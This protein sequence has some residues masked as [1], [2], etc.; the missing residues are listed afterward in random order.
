MDD[1]SRAATAETWDQKKE[2]VGQAWAKTQE[3]YG[4]VKASTTL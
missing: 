1:E 2:K 3:A 4:K